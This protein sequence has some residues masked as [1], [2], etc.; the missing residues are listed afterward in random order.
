MDGA[1]VFTAN[2][3]VFFENV[4]NEAFRV[5]WHDGWWFSIESGRYRLNDGDIDLIVGNLGEI[6]YQ[7]PLKKPFKFS[8]GF[9]DSGSTDIFVLSWSRGELITCFEVKQVPHNNL[10]ELKENSKII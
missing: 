8:Q 3:K 6:K 4:S 9:N 10:P 5:K 1:M 7:A 2:K